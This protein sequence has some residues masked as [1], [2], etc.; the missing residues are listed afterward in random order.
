MLYLI[1][2]SD[3]IIKSVFSGVPLWIYT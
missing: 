1:H 3:I 2:L